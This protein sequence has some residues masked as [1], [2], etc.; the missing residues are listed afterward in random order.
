MI[1]LL[2]VSK[3]ITQVRRCLVQLCIGCTCLSTFFYF[4]FSCRDCPVHALH[5][6]NLSLTTATIIKVSISKHGCCRASDLDLTDLSWIP[7]KCVSNSFSF[8]P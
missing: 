8:I 7:S 5:K 1:I 3:I 4:Y 6:I 2:H